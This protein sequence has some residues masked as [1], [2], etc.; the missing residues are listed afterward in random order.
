MKTITTIQWQDSTKHPQVMSGDVYEVLIP[1]LTC[2]SGLV[3]LKGDRLIVMR[4]TKEAPHNEVGPLGY[5]WIVKTKH[6]VSVWATLESCITRG[7]IQKVNA[8][9]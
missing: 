3:H 8:E 2:R 9:T 7:L 4:H 6:D 1:K 5:N